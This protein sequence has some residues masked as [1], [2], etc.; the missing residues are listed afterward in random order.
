M[1]TPHCGGFRHAFAPGFG[2]PQE[3]EED[4]HGALQQYSLKI[5]TVNATSWGSMRPYLRRVAADIVLVQEHKLGPGVVPCAIAWLRRRGWNAVM[6]PAQRG[7]NG[8]WSAGAAVLARAHIGMALP[9]TGSETVV[10]H[11]AVAARL[12]APGCRPFTAV[13]TYLHDGCGLGK[14]NLEV[15]KQIGEFMTAQGE[16]AL[17]VVG[18]DFQVTPQQ[19]AT[20]SFARETGTALVASGNPSG[21]CRTSTSAREID[22][23][24]VSDA[25]ATG[26]EEVRAL[27]G[28][29][30]RTHLPV[31][32]AFRPRLTSMR[33]ITVRRPPPLTTELAARA[34]ELAEDAPKEELTTEELHVRFGELFSKWA[35]EAEKE[36]AE[37]TYGGQ[38][39]P[40]FGLRG[41]APVMVWRSVL[42][43]KPKDE[44]KGDVHL[45]HWRSLANAALETLRLA[46][47]AVRGPSADDGADGG[48]GD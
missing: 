36:L 34:K 9:T 29:G 35:D 13:S 45:V 14:R 48:H 21:T 11:R 30:I 31:E 32:V 25:M 38:S 33:A 8:G 23:F 28:T 17:F 4:G 2:E 12:E 3:V 26:I 44:A 46:M 6:T 24:F 7:P 27:A 42:P 20:L 47:D 40:K 15:M 37:C 18:G 19:I 41:K 5:T 10:P 22:F 43:E 1:Q 39:M 16:G